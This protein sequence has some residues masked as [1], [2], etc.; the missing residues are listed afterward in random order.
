MYSIL[1][2]NM[3]H[4][5]ITS[6]SLLYAGHY[7]KGIVHP[8]KPCYKPLKPSFIFGTQIKIF[9]DEIRELSDLESNATDTFKAQKGSNN[10]NKIVHVK[11][12]V[13][14][15]FYKATRLL[16]VHKENKNNNYIQQFILCVNL[17]HAFTRVPQ[18]MRVVL[19]MQETGE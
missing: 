18:R 10:I 4:I 1:L 16:F 7:V 5:R 11:S 2:G 12:V 9:F 3:W 19:L 17:R 14:P 6:I 15:Q 13:Q 8:N